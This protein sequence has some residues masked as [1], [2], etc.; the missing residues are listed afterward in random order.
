M[1]KVGAEQKFCIVCGFGW[2]IKSITVV[3]ESKTDTRNITWTETFTEELFCPKC[4]R[5]IEADR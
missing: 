4:G 3:S 2:K 5:K 1:L